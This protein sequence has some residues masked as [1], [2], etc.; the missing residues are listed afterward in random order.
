MNRLRA[1]G[2]RAA[3]T[4][5][6]LL[7]GAAVLAAP[8]AAHAADQEP[9][10]T[11]QFVLAD[12]INRVAGEDCTGGPAGYEGAGDIRTAGN[13]T[14]W[15]CALLGSANDTAR[16]GRLTVVGLVGCEQPGGDVVSG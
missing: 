1:L 9:V 12:S 5:A 6:A 16:P 14:V 3:T 8:T 4:S 15:K 7:T 2:H 13:D 11:C 10:Y